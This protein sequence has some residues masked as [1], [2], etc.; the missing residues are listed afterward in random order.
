VFEGKAGRKKTRLGG[1]SKSLKTKIL[2]VGTLDGEERGGG[3]LQDRSGNKR[4]IRLAKNGRPGQFREPTSPKKKKKKR[5]TKLR[6]KKKKKNTNILLP[7]KTPFLLLYLL[8]RPRG[9]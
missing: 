2:V 5:T 3:H 4:T 1:K 7:G 8:A 6:K 9:T